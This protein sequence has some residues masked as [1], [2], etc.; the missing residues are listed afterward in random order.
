MKSRIESPKPGSVVATMTL[1]YK[2]DARRSVSDIME[3]IWFKMLF[4]DPN[5]LSINPTALIIS[6]LST[7]IF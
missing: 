6:D 3:D 4:G 5:L 1:E 7:S 2:D